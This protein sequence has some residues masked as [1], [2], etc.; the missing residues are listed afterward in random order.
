MA[1]RE[2]R[3]VFGQIATPAFGLKQ[4]RL[5]YARARYDDE[6]SLAYPKQERIHILTAL[7]INRL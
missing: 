2:K 3:F 6:I 4:I 1:A 7:I 5:T